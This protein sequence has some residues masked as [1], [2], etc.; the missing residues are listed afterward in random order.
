MVDNKG[1]LQPYWINTSSNDIIQKLIS[2]SDET[3]KE[4]VELLLNG[5][6]V[7]KTIN[8]NI[9]YAET[10]TKLGAL[11][12]FLLFSGY[13]T[14][15]DLRIKNDL[16][17]ADLLIPNIEIRGFYRSTILNWFEQD[18]KIAKQYKLMLES[19]IKGDTEVF[20]KTFTRFALT[21]FS[22]FDVPSDESENFYHAF[23]LGLL[24]SLQGTHD[25]ISNRESGLG[26]Y[27][28]S[29]I[30]QV[31][32]KPTIIIELKTVDEAAKETL[33]KASSSALQ[34]INSRKY[35]EDFKARGFEKILKLGIAFQGKEVLIQEA[36]D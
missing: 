2:E 3:V 8:E 15:K 35:A 30:P 18:M 13:L 34:Q 29:V 22:Y 25:V 23:S 20:K 5:H 11:W 36:W 7:E 16:L 28:I 1:S 12:N 14:F 17:T 6:S 24:A 26:R 19:L 33:E 31:K 21:S 32:T 10:F 4:E 9:V 27:D